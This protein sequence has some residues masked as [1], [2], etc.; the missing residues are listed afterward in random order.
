MADRQIVEEWINKADEDLAFAKANLEQGLEFYSQICFH[1][2]QAVEKY[3]KSYIIAKGLDFRKIHNLIDLLQICGQT[4]ED[5]NR[6]YDEAELLNPFY[7]G[8]R[9]PDFVITFSK[10][11]AEQALQAAEEIALFVKSKL[12]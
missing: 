11:R 12:Q 10:S 3:L 8:T 1:F 2:H 6:F 4:E 9:Y 7:I 5:F